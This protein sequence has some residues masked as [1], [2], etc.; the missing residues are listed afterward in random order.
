MN[1]LLAGVLSKIDRLIFLATI[2]AVVLAI[3]C[4][5]PWVWDATAYHLPF[6]A[7]QLGVQDYLGISNL[8]NERYQ[9]FPV[10]WRYALAPGLILNSPR[11]YILPNLLAAFS[12]ALCLHRLLNISKSMAMATTLCFPISYLGFASPYQDYFT[13]MFALTGGLLAAQGVFVITYGIDELHG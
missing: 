8:F 4:F 9:G 7:R 6:T 10:L 11:L 2:A 12:A 13:N 5:R 3:L 1:Q